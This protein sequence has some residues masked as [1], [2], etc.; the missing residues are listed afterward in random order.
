MIRGPTGTASAGPSE[1]SDLTKLLKEAGQGDHA[2]K[3]VFALVHGEL[4]DL[5]AARI[6][7]ERAGHTLQATALVHEAWLRLAGDEEPAFETR[8]HFFAA[9]ARAMERV[10]TDH[11]RRVLAAKRGGGVERLPITGIDLAGSDDPELALELSDAL[12]A[13]EREDARAAE[14]ARLR[15]YA[16]MEVAAVAEALGLSERTAARDWAF[17]RAR[18][19][20]SLSEDGSGAPGGAGERAP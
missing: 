19:A 9:A 1:A 13:L 6:A 15:L 5:A 10:L 18:L 20:Q 16:G 7:R 12:E 3:A 11:A 14:I 4:R 8:R 2:W 17:A